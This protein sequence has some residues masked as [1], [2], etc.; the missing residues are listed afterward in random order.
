MDRF[1]ATKSITL[2]ISGAYLHSSMDR[3][4]AEHYYIGKLD[5][6]HLHSSMDRF[7][8]LVA[9][10]ELKTTLKFTFQYG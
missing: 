6:K 4:E 3:F 8:G 10:P 9:D 7:E 1:E 2:S 5:N